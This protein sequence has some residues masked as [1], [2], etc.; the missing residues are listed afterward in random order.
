MPSLILVRVD[1]LPTA[2][3]HVKSFTYESF[4]CVGLIRSER[5]IY[6]KINLH[7]HVCTTSLGYVQY[8]LCVRYG[9]IYVVCKQMLLTSLTDMCAIFVC[10]YIAFFCVDRIA[11]FMKVDDA[12]SLLDSK[13]KIEWM[14]VFKINENES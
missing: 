10:E 11:V 5:T 6:E 12:V 8:M 9:N 13:R 1:I 7:L 3:T 2:R 14:W 4:L